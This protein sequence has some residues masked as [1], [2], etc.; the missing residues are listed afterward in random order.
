MAISI[1]M[2]GKVFGKLLAIKKAENRG[3]RVLWLFRCDCGI[4]KEIQACRVIGG[5]IKSCGCLKAINAGKANTTHGLY[6]HPL[7]KVWNGMKERCLNKNHHK[8][9]SYGARGI[10]VSNRWM[11]FINFYNDMVGG[12]SKGLILDRRENNLGY[13]KG[14]CRWVNAKVS[15]QNTRNNRL[16]WN[17]V[18][19]IRSA[20]M[21]AKQLAVYFNVGVST[22]NDV[23]QNLT[24]TI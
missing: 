19:F 22:I 7:Y 5:I 20:K 17:K 15:A 21:T 2:E 23:R 24:W 18:I 3:R 12:Y 8:Y 11:K 10:T 6:K 1:Q 16:D 14:N 4:E 13:S 9:S